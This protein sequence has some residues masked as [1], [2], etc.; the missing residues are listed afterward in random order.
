MQ[1]LPVAYLEL[2]AVYARSIGQGMRTLAVCAAN[3]GE[4]V[5]MLAEALARRAQ[6][7][8]RRVLLVEMNLYQPTM[9][10][11]FGIERQAW[12]PA[13][14]EKGQGALPLIHEIQGFGVLPASLAKEASMR[15]REPHVLEHSLNEWLNHYDHVIFDT[16]P[17]N[18]T[19]QHNIPAER[20]AAACE[21]CLLLVLAGKTTQSAVIQARRR[22]DAAN[23]RLIGAVVNDCYNP[24]LAAE[25]VREVRRLERWVPRMAGWLKRRVMDSPLLNVPV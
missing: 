9:A 2:E 23:V 17:L 15:L 22:L 16:S 19:N 4:G 13:R 8:G 18:A 14:S 11:H 5:S 7:A 21:G 25:M 10:N 3:S 24:T 6:A 1:R 20:I 12:L